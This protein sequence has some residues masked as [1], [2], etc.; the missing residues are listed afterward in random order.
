MNDF[1]LCSAFV[2][3]VASAVLFIIFSF[4][5]RE[6][7]NTAARICLKLGF[8]FL[9]FMV[10]S[11]WYKAGRP[12]FANMYEALVLF[13]WSTMVVYMVFDYLYKAKLLAVPATIISLLL[14]SG[15]L[16]QDSAIKPL[17]PALQS[18]WM[19]LH[20]VTYFIGYA[21]LSLAC[22]LS[23]LY[24]ALARKESAQAPVMLVFDNLSYQLI[25]FAFPFITIGMT[26]GS[27]WANV[28]WG[29][30]WFWDPKETCSLITW[31][32][33]VL[34]LHVRILKGWKG[35]KAAY[36]ALLGFLA[37]LFTFIGVNYILPGLHSYAQ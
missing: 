26:T 33:Y 37:T 25:I 21:A 29:S 6:Q 27:A 11:R 35:K 7:W 30:Y 18:S 24:L 22:L 17:M 15:A 2:S 20:V 8:S 3:Y 34:Y 10:G 28:A 36:L 5:R 16:T 4:S 9:S 13:A 19:G 14:L 32:V 23:G 1:L 12:P 31:L